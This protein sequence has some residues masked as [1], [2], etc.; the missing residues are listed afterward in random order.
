[1]TKESQQ[2]GQ[3]EQ[4]YQ[5]YLESAQRAIEMMRKQ[6]KST[7]IMRVNQGGA[8]LN[9][10]RSKE[11]HSMLPEVAQIPNSTLSM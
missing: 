10:V 4:Y 9:V 3:Q 8:D 11:S 6:H 1:M 2:P 5:F 7:S